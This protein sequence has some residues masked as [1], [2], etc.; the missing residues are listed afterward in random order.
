[1]KRRLNILS[2]AI[3]DLTAPALAHIT[4]DELMNIAKERMDANDHS[5]ALHIYDVVLSRRKAQEYYAE[6]YF[7]KGEIHYRTEH[8]IDAIEC[9]QLAV[10]LDHTGAMLALAAMYRW[11]E[12]GKKP[13]Y[14]KAIALYETA[15]RLGNTQ[16]IFELGT[17]HFNGEGCPVNLDIAISLFTQAESL[18]IEYADKLLIEAKNSL[19]K[20]TEGDIAGEILTPSSTASARKLGFFETPQ[21]EKKLPACNAAKSV[22]RDDS[23][24]I[25]THSKLNS[26]ASAFVPKKGP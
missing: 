22:I 2:S 11:C 1:M 13:R 10:N 26:N 19:F 4:S 6:I 9:F 3:S 23:S 15:I 17:L 21:T 14:S 24:T 20:Q 25:S 8:F 7:R 18:G 12:D 16:A 5:R